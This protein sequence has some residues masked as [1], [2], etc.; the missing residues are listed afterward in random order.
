MIIGLTGTLASGKGTVSE[1][2]VERGFGH[3]SAREF[4]TREIIKRGLKVNRDNMVFVANDLRERYS[5]SY[6]AIKLYEEAAEKGGNCVIESLRTPGEVETL[7]E[8]KDFYLI[9]TDA[10]SKARYERAI[11][12][13]SETDKISFEEFLANEKREMQ[14]EEKHKQN[15][16]KCMEMA[17]FLITNDGSVEEFRKKIEDVLKKI[18]SKKVGRRENYISWDEYFMGV[19]I[20]SGKRSK[21]PNTQVGACIVNADKKIVGIGYNGLPMGCSDL[22]FPWGREGDFLDTKYPY[23][24]HAELNAILNSSGRN[25][26][27]STIYVAL[28]PCN[29]CAKAIIQSGIKKVVYLSDKYKNE[30]FTI[31][32]KKMFD[33]SG[34]KYEMLAPKENEILLKF[35][36]E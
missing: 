29:E 4:L 2:L 1:F 19:S 3:Y 28:F 26:K 18:E 25:L 8:K 16:K 24:V 32:A 20:L 5:P 30:N 10:D 33:A 27:N 12:R 9:A 36:Q 6:V 31:A 23:V 7:K 35:S 11:K 34:V 17:D 22:N 15:I 21:D 13:M 14:S